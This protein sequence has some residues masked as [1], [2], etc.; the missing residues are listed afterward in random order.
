[1]TEKVSVIVPVY[2]AE[3]Y[4]H[5]CVQSIL[6]QSYEHWEA[7]F[8]NDGS[9]D[10]SLSILQEYAKSDHRFTIINKSNGGVSSARNAGLD[11]LQTEYFTFVDADDSISPDFFQ[12]TLE[13]ALS[14]DCD[15]VVTDFSF[16]G[17]A[18]GLYFS[19]LVQM[20]PSQYVKCIPG[21]PWAKLYKSQIVNRENRRLRFHEDM[22]CAEDT[23]FTISYAARIRNFYAISGPMYNYN[24]DAETSLIHRSR[25]GELRFEQYV[26]IVEAPWRAYR[27]I[28]NDHSVNHALINSQWSYILYNDLWKT[29]F[30]IRQRLTCKDAKKKL[31]EHFLLRHKDFF[32]HVGFCKRIFAPQR[33][34]Y[35]YQMLK[36]IWRN[37]K[38]FIKHC[39][40]QKI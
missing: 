30:I 16:Q 2:N 18:C 21:T 39:P 32:P 38:R 17:K 24:F 15:L 19:G 1:M 28:S 23:V 34:P 27:D 26:Y 31:F 8:V 37:A 25:R 40:P 22:Q 12:K 35:I 9:T 33:H 7:I 10:S 4:L 13:A 3:K 5:R 29:Y 36:Y 14:C 6:N 20:N 11:A